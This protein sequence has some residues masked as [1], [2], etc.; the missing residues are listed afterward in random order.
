MGEAAPVWGKSKDQ[1]QWTV[2]VDGSSVSGKALD[3]AV[4]FLCYH[5]T[6]QLPRRYRGPTEA[7]PLGGRLVSLP[8]P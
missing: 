3:A 6:L 8:R 7:Q 1:V 2:L 5:V 4:S